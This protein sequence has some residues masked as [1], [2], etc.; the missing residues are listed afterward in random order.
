MLRTGCSLIW[1]PSDGPQNARR[2]PLAGLAAERTWRSLVGRTCAVADKPENPPLAEGNIPPYRKPDR[3]MCSHTARSAPT[4]IGGRHC[5]GVFGCTCD[6]AD[7]VH[8]RLL[9]FAF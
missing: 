1:T 7:D 8:H 9:A 6:F 5:C 4:C 2:F 3:G